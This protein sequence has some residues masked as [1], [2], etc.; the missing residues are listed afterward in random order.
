MKLICGASVIYLVLWDVVFNGT[1]CTKSTFPYVFPKSCAVYVITFLCKI[2]VKPVLSLLVR[3]TCSK[4]VL[5]IMSLNSLVR[6]AELLERNSF[7]R[8]CPVICLNTRGQPSAPGNTTID[9]K[10]SVSSENV[11]AVAFLKRLSRQALR[12]TNPLFVATK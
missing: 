4:F 2:V 1:T 5:I 11:A 12:T 8:C 9:L 10:R 3:K 6:L 7:T